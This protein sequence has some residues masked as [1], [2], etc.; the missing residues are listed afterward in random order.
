MTPDVI[1]NLVHIF[2]YDVDYQTRLS[3]SD[4]LEV[5]YSTERDGADGGRSPPRSSTRR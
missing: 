5:I 4:S 3:A 2:S 1:K